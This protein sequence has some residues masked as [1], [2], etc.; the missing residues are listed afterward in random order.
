M[1]ENK[2]NKVNDPIE[3]PEENPAGGELSTSG[4]SLDS[5]NSVSQNLDPIETGAE[6]PGADRATENQDQDMA[7][8]GE[9]EAV[10]RENHE[11]GTDAQESFPR[12][13]VEDLR[14]ENAKY[15]DRAKR[16]D[17]L[18]ARLHTA[19]VAADGRLA[20]PEDLEFNAEHLDDDEALTAAIGDLVARKPGLRAQKVGGD[21]GAGKRGAPATPPADLISLIRGM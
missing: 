19:L 18:A 2:I 17:D 9:G 6:A 11:D 20:D 8:G 5:S 13:Y 21:V 7:G 14:K 12:A 10:G 16:A 4:Q 3:T 15:R 1:A